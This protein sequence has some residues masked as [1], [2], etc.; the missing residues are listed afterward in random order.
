MIFAVMYDV[1]AAAPSTV[2]LQTAL[3]SFLSSHSKLQ[4]RKWQWERG[5]LEMRW[6]PSPFLLLPILALAPLQT[7][8][9]LTLFPVLHYVVT[10][11]GSPAGEELNGERLLLSVS[12][13]I[14]AS[15]TMWCCGTFHHQCYEYM[16][17]VV[18]ESGQNS[19]KV[20]E[21]RSDVSQVVFEDL[22][23]IR[24]V[25]PALRIGN[26]KVWL[27]FAELLPWVS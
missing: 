19:L 7:R 4:V 11:R 21:Q 16:Q 1:A 24:D 2:V 10:Y 6:E 13:W 22:S 26:G 23:Y 17:P 18:L 9:G 12:R 27:S 5:F 14:M 20:P 25:M 8:C 3:Q 15:V